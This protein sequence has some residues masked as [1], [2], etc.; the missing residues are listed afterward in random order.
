VDD[1][2][3]VALS[4]SPTDRYPSVADFAADV[5]RS[6]AEPTSDEPPVEPRGTNRFLGV[7]GLAVVAA[8]GGL[9]FLVSGQDPYESALNADNVL[10]KAIF[11]AHPKPSSGEV[12]AILANHPP[13]MLYIPE[14]PFVAGRLAHE[15]TDVGGDKAEQKML[16]AYLIDIFELPNLEG[17]PPTTGLSHT[18]AKAL[19]E[20]HGKR[21]CTDDEWEKACRG[22]QNFVYSYGDTFDEEFCGRGLDEPHLAGALPK[23]SSSWGVYDI[24]G[25]LREWTDTPR[26]EGRH[27]VKGGQS[28]AAARGTRC[29][30]AT[31]LSD[32][33]ADPTLGARCCRDVNAPA[34]TPP[35]AADPATPPG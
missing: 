28:G 4:P 20:S 16:P 27:L 13:N 3:E 23:C 26:G 6:F 9:L 5:H 34:W 8:L 33:F 21:L 35:A 30:A 24:S 17:A 32:Q 11:E 15:P 22:P 12:R 25:N 19:C 29:A 7:I 10:R 18:Q 1:I 31:D 2:V 14:G